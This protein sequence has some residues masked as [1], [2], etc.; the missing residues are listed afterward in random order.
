MFDIINKINY[1]VNRLKC[2]QHKVW[3]K[4][5]N[6]NNLCIARLYTIILLP[7]LYLAP[8]SLL[9]KINEGSFSQ[10]NFGK[11]V[12]LTD[13]FSQ[14]GW[15]TWLQSKVWSDSEVQWQRSGVRTASNGLI[16]DILR[17]IMLGGSSLASWW[18]EG[19]T[20]G[21]R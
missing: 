20:H 18:H 9:Q 11:C 21:Q 12:K 3:K 14:P 10:Y 16:T 4:K 13:K 17:Q 15:L 19:M 7:H 5:I 8:V 2:M 1:I 6:L